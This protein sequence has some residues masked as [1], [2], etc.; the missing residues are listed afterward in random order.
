VLEKP[1]YLRRYLM[2]KDPEKDYD[3]L[4]ES[5]RKASQ[6]TN[7]F[8]RGGGWRCRLREEHHDSGT[9]QIELL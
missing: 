3:G 9:N 6:F 1:G 7:K 8:L 2:V 5:A 4:I